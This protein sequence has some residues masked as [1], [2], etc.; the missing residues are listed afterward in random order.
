MSE[1]A[2]PPTPAPVPRKTRRSLLIA[3]AAVL[4]LGAG[5]GVTAYW[6]ARRAPAGGDAKPHEAADAGLI[7]LEPFVVNLADQGGAHFLRVSIRLIVESPA[8][9]EKIQKNDV[10]LLRARSAILELLTRQT[11]DRLVTAEGKAAL[12][13]AIATRL[14]T[15]LTGTTVLD[16]LFTDF[17]VQF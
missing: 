2:T 7:S 16:V 8:Q 9:A 10:T 15:V 3:I 1:P 5:G 11:G 6:A 4:V 17:V 12:K 14:A 13:Q